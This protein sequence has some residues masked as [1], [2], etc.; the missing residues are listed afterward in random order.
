MPVGRFSPTEG[1][2]RGHRTGSSPID[3]AGLMLSE[4]AHCNSVRP[5]GLKSSFQVASARYTV[6]RAK[7]LHIHQKL[8]KRVVVAVN[9]PIRNNSV[10]DCIQLKDTHVTM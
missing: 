3:D 10:V 7:E 9:G 6:L 5:R 4:E 1:T 8:R 2:S